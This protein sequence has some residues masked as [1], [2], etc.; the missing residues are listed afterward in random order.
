[1]IYIVEDNVSMRRA[2]E[3][4]LE[5]DGLEYKSFESA[6]SFISEII[7]THKD[8]IILDIDLPIMS[9]LELLNKFSM[10]K[11]SIP[12][13]VVTALEDV[14]TQ[15]N[16]MRYGVMAFLRKPVDGITLMELIK[17]NSQS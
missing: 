13:I 5:S 11:K 4:F 6:I 8:L 9:G 17:N 15:V 12:V 14:D 16:C 1:M 2:F 10:E 3:I 7:P